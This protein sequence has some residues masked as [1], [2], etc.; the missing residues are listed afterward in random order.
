MLII[1]IFLF[2]MSIAREFKLKDYVS[3]KYLGLDGDNFL[4]FKEY[5]NSMIFKDKKSSYR[6]GTVNVQVES[7]PSISW[8]YDKGNRYMSI[9]ALHGGGNQRFVAYHIARDLVVIGTEVEADKCMT[10]NRSTMRL[11]FAECNWMYNWPNQKFQVTDVDGVWHGDT[12]H[13]YYR[14]DIGYSV[15]YGRCP[16]CLP[17]GFGSEEQGDVT[18]YTTNAILNTVKSITLPVLALGYSVWF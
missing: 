16:G 6:K 3:G 10:L 15:D 8:T 18:D 2:K 7:I 13:G 14:G 5:K 12:L 4:K 9:F 11:Y 1:L 17:G